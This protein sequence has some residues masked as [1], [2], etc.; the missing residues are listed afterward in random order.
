MSDSQY[1]VIAGCGRLGS[2]LSNQLSREGHSVVV[3]DKKAAGFAHLS[4]DFSGFR[5]EGDAT[6]MLTLKAAKTHM[7]HAL[8]ATTHDD[9]VNLMVAQV[10]RELFK[11]PKVMARV[12]DPRREQIYSR[13]AIETVCPT[14][15]AAA[16]LLERLNAPLGGRS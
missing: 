10:A 12:F 2:Y 8:I 9:N 1:I 4:A 15:V 16:M 11:V 3:I 5:L 13:L 14:T 7:A 6:Q